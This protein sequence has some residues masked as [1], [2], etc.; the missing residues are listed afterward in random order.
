M[1]DDRAAPSPTGPA[2]T[3]PAPTGSAP[4]D[5]APSSP[6]PTGAGRSDLARSVPL[7]RPTFGERLVEAVGRTGPL[8]AGIDPTP[9]LLSAWALPDD[10][11]GLATFVRRSLDAYAGVVGVIKPQL[12]FFERHGAAGLA[13]L[14]DLLTEARRAGLLV[15]ADAKRGDIGSTAA[16]YADAWLGRGPL[17]AD[18]MTAVAYLGLGALQPMVD[19]ARANGRGLFV[20]VRSSNPEGRNLQSA[21]TAGGRS[22]EDDLLAGLAAV[23]AADGAP[24]GALGAVIGV[25]GRP[26]GSAPAGLGGPLLAPGLGT[27]GARWPTPPPS[28]PG[29][30]PA[31]WWSTSPVRCWPPG[32]TE[33]R[34]GEPPRP[35]RRGSG[36]RSGKDRRLPRTEPRPAGA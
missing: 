32:P 33:G 15:I 20:V 34:Y 29:A 30:G 19:V 35:L 11:T 22:V 16:G 23:N 6:A 12:A 10:P 24:V 3:A 2:P 1:S 27:Q 18:A 25:T 7:A 26:W 14:E 9:E 5:P 36:R 28:S 8:C 31:A 4:S 17:A 21:V 13:V